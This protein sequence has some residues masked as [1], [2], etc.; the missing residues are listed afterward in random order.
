MPKDFQRSDRL[1]SQ[2]HRELS[3]L[4]SQSLKDPR[5]AQPSIL[6]VQVTKDIS[7]AKVYFSVLN[8][9]ASQATQDAL[10]HAAGFLQRELGKTLKSRITPKL[11]FIFDDTDIRGRSMDELIDSVIAH[12]RAHPAKD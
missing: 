11:M 1:A 6:D 8:A 7:L 5:L 3:T 9:E 4:I 10:N 2:I 12:D